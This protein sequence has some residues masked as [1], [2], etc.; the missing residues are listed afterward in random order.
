MNKH[1]LMGI[2]VTSSLIASSVTFAA[3][4][5]VVAVVDGKNI[6]LEEVMSQKDTLGKEFKNIPED[7]LFPL[8][9]NKMVNDLIIAKAARESDIADKEEVKKALELMTQQFLIQ[10]FLADKIQGTI[11]E[12]DVKKKYEDLVAN[13]PD[14]KEAKLRHILV[15]DKGKADQ[16]IKALKNRVD[17]KKLVEKSEDKATAKRGGEIG[18][19]AKS[20]LPKEIAE[21]VF[22]VKAGGYT[23][24]PVKTELGWHVFMVDDYRDA[25]PPS[26]EE[27]KEELKTLMAEEALIDFMKKLREKS[28]VQMMTKE[29][30]PLP[31]P[32]EEEAPKKS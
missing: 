31:A 20:M 17:F 16:I 4:D 21:K 3:S 7:K 22:E 8:L 26:Y 2:A 25:K 11:K 10:A 28:D 1:F 27:S 29:G 19:M 24:E 13:F 12:G 6:T 32:K 9:Q 15:S 14:E 23:S 30:Q 18:Y 5:T